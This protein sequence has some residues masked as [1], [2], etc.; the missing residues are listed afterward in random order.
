[1]SE[2]ALGE[3]VQKCAKK[4]WGVFLRVFLFSHMSGKFG[5]GFCRAGGCARCRRGVRGAGGVD[6]GE[7]GQKWPKMAKMGPGAPGGQKWPKMGI[8]A[9]LQDFFEG[10]LDV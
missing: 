5:R 10:G 2:F 4:F 1:M 6:F 3:N 8:L 9:R 7:N